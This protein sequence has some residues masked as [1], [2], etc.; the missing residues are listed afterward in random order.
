MVV[1]AGIATPALSASLACFDAYRRAHLPANL[2]QSQRDYF[3][4]H[5][6][7]R[8]DGPGKDAQGNAKFVH[9]EWTKQL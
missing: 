1:R 9:S 2:T 3:G 8:K 7:Q 4:A 5:T 6:Y